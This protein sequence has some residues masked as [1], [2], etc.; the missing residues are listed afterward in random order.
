M[1]QHIRHVRVKTE[2]K[3]ANRHGFIL[4]PSPNK[5]ISFGESPSD[6]GDPAGPSYDELFSQFHRILIDVRLD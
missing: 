2:Q 6:R 5:M 1:T 4:A 3:T